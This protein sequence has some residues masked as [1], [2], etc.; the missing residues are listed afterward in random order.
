MSGLKVSKERELLN[1]KSV[2]F[3]ERK[4]QIEK[5][6]KREEEMRKRA[7]NSP[8]DR[9]LQVNKK[10][11]ELEDELMKK[12]P[13]AYRIWRFL[14]QHMDK[15]NAVIVSQEVL[16]EIFDVSRT[17]IWRA[18]KVLDEREFIKI[19]KSGTTNVY[20]LNDDMVWNSWGSNRVYSKFSANVIV[21]ESEQTEDMKRELKDIKTENQKNVKF[22]ESKN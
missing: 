6:E 11:Y 19:Y 5:D 12:N 4:A 16:T 21:S 8:F 22:K 10:T 17:T 1:P 20:A 2:S 14:A 13:L 15:Y 9:F 7:K 18:I 3:E